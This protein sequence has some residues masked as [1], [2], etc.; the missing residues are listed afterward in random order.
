MEKLQKYHQRKDVCFRDL[1]T[2]F[3][4]FGDIPRLMKYLKNE[5]FQK[6]GEKEL[7][8][9]V[10]AIVKLTTCNNEQIEEKS[11]QIM[12]YLVRLRSEVK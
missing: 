4:L 6:Q 9:I 7:E 11:S 1:V 10:R 12:G 3:V 8:L 5:E 2:I